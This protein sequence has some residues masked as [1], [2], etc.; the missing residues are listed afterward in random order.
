[1]ERKRLYAYAAVLIALAV[2]LIAAASGYYTIASL[3]QQLS[4]YKKQQG[5]LTR[6]ITAQHLKDMDAARRAWTSANQREYIALQNEGISVEADTLRT[7]DFA[8]V[9]DLRDPSLNRVDATPGD[10]EPGEAV[11]Y[12]GQYYLDN[13]TRAS[14]W[15]ASYTVNT[16][17]HAVSGL[18]STIIQDAAL[19]YYNSALAPIIY[20]KL[21]VAN[22]SVVGYTQ[23]PVD[24][25]YLPESGSWM[26]VTEYQYSLKYGSL[27][28]YLLVKTYVNA[29]SGDVVGVDVSRPYY[30]SVTGLSY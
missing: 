10:V 20:Q 30:D 13:M 6:I 11:V 26:D 21:G 22:G 3:N 1:M 15:T 2:L 28:P 8:I 18:T 25:S 5:D 23:R 27:K 7:K 14:G 17:T 16:T 4:L 24:S 29:T 19:D 9:L 12:L